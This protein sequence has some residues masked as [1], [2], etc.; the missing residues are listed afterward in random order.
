[1][2]N[3]Q[4]NSDAKWM[5]AG[6]LTAFTASLCCITPVVAFLAGIGGIA[7]TFSW[8]EPFRPYLI[9]LTVLLLGFAW[10]QKLKP[11]W[12]PKCM[13][14]DNH[15]FWQTKKF[16]GIATVVAGLLLTFPSYSGAFFPQQN[17]QKVVVVQRNQ[18]EKITLAIEGMTCTG[19]EATVENA[20]IGVKG[21]LKAEASYANKEAII[22]YDKSKTGPKNIIKAI[23]ATG[24]KVKQ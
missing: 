16:L 19:C 24:F 5:G 17:N 21:V 11:Q 4:E 3:H 10:Y 13:C 2:K 22:T 7:S 8:I 15:S 9:G 14:K 1:M 18:V 20:A 6:L 23:N 12:D